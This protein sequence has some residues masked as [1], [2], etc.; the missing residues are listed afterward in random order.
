MQQN[1]VAGKAYDLEMTYD[2]YTPVI[3][4]DGTQVIWLGKNNSDS[5][6]MVPIKPHVIDMGIVTGQTQSVRRWQYDNA[7]QV[8][9]TAVVAN[10]SI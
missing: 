1:L 8:T 10:N 2:Q 9:T 6:V 3:R 5:I 7:T 4:L